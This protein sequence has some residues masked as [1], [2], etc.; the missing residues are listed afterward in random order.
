[1]ASSSSSY[2][3]YGTIQSGAG[4]T[5]TWVVAPPTGTYNILVYDMGNSVYMHKITG[6]SLSA[7]GGTAY[8]SSRTTY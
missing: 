1:L 2:V 4:S 6:V 7:S 3:G 8:W 5:V